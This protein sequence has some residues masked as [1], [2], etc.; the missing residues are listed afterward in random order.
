MITGTYVLEACARAEALMV[1]NTASRHTTVIAIPAEESDETVLAEEAPSTSV[2]PGDTPAGKYKRR[3][4]PEGHVIRI[5]QRTYELSELCRVFLGRRLRNFFTFT[6]AGDLYGITWTFV[7]V[8]GS[9]LSEHLSIGTEYDY[10]IYVLI[11]MVITVPVSCM[12]ISLQIP[13]QLTFL[14]ARTTMLLLMLGTLLAAFGSD[15][16]HFGSQLH[17]AKET[18]LANFSAI[19][20]VLQL[21]VFS[22][23]FQFSVPGLTAET[24]DKDGMVQIISPS[25]TYIYITNLILSLLM[26][27]YF[28]SSTE[29]SSNLNWLQY[30]GGSWDGEGE[31][32]RAWWATGISSYIVLF[33]ALDGLAVYPLIVISLGD[34]LMGACFED[35]VHQM[36][37]NWKIR[38]T[39]RL[40]ASLPQAIGS[41]FL[42]DLSVM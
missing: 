34:I 11:F 26:A 19:V 15:G 8:F 30:H 33:A 22:T 1:S 38:V 5:H 23:A 2:P 18:P 28:G 40:L 20:T 4:L 12:R 35:K 14:A 10:Q 37:E 9:S 25:V 6:T 13:F 32:S 27:I 16:S 3:Y 41:L 29:A 7:A 21:S 31:F 24:G 36:Q 42:K 39:F 17:P